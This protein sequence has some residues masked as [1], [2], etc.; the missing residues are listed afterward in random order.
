[1]KALGTEPLNFQSKAEAQDN[2]KISKTRRENLIA[3]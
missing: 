3:L 1:M 2:V